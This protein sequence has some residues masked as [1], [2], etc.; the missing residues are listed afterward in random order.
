M[1][2]KTKK[3][4]QQPPATSKPDVEIVIDK[5]LYELLKAGR[6]TQVL[7][8]KELK[9]KP[10]IISV[11]SPED[12]EPIV[13]KVQHM[14]RVGHGYLPKGY[15]EKYKA[16]QKTTRFHVVPVEPEPQVE[17]APS[18]QSTSPTE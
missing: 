17:D 4:G 10:E 12:D 6:I 1:T 7:T 14:D 3:P 8:W 11:S 9:E 13:L 18:D 2:K 15:P 16:N 5:V